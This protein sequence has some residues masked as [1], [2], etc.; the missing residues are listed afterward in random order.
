MALSGL[1]WA[2]GAEAGD[3][4]LKGRRGRKLW[5]REGEALEE[6][7][8]ESSKLFQVCPIRRNAS[9]LSAIAAGTLLTHCDA[10]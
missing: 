10:I 4:S 6:L 9:D 3:V 2:T 8:A 5:L 1:D 7:R